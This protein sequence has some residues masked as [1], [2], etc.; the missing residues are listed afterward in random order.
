VTW[1][2]SAAL[3]R[4]VADE[5][6]RRRGGG[7]GRCAQQGERFVTWAKGLA[8]DKRKESIRQDAA[9]A[10]VQLGAGWRW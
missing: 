7:L 9:A 5:V 1:D 2:V 6:S 4:E 10:L 8:A 3:A